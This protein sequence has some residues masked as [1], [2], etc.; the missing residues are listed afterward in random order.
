M[1]FNEEPELPIYMEWG[2]RSMASAPYFMENV[3]AFVRRISAES[4]YDEGEVKIRWLP[5][6]RLGTLLRVTWWSPEMDLLRTADIRWP[7]GAIICLRCRGQQ[8]LEWSNGMKLP[9]TRCLGEGFTGN[10]NSDDEECLDF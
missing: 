4:H 10:I 7:D 2:L 8:V 1:S 9:C 5:K 6:H 3:C